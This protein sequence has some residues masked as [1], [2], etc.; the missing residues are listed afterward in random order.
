MEISE[1]L[2]I[3]KA[4]G[5]PSRLALLGALLDKPRYV[6]ELAQRTHLAESTVSFHLKKLESAKLVSRVR[7][8]YYAMYSI[9][10][11]SLQVTLLEMVSSGDAGKHIQEERG[12]AYR[13]KVIRTFFENGRLLRLPV[14]KKKR[15]IVLEAFAALF[16]EGLIYAEGEVD[17]VIKEKFDDY[18]TIRRELIDEGLLFRKSQTYWVAKTLEEDGLQGSP[19]HKQKKEGPMDRK[20][21]LKRQY[22]ENPPSAGV[23]KITNTAN[24]KIFVGKGLNVQGK[25]NGQKAQLRWGGHKNPDIQADWNRYG[26]ESFAFEVLDYLAPP[27]DPGQDMDEDL[28]ALRRLWLDKLRPYGDKGYNEPPTE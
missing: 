20:A 5:D 18:C 19:A 25:L 8:Q 23:Y 11:E 9:N 10:R 1:S 26:S 6:E 16:R 4:L 15:R 3:V 12:R 7:Q 28:E 21:T 13:E 27:D 17:R 24:G 14:Q 22:K 2:A